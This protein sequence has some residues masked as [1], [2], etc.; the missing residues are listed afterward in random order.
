MIMAEDL[1]KMWMK[2]SLT[3]EESVDL[4][5]PE[6]ELH[7]G[8]TRGKFYVLGK[9]IADRMVSKETIK[10]TL[11]RWWKLSG[12][13]SFQVLGENLFL[14]EFT[15]MEDKKWILEGRPWIFEGSLF[16]IEDFDGISSP[17]SFNFDRAGFWVRMIDLPLACIN[18]TT[19]KRIGSTVGLVE[20]VDTGKDG[21]GW[22]EFLRVKIVEDLSKPLAHGRMLKI[23]GKSNWIA[24]QY[25]HLPKFCFHCAIINHGKLDVHFGVR[26]TTRRI[27]LNMVPGCGRLHQR[28]GRKGEEEDN[29][30][31]QG[32]P[33]M[34]SQ[35]MRVYGTMFSAPR[36]WERRM[37]ATLLGFLQT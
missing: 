18:Q 6:E 36:S 31:G 12:T 3:E 20:A 15:D 29:Q 24:F 28:E 23:Q 7:D 22:G 11:S 34:R 9:L 8:V 13:L 21:I 4:D 10:T 17:S 30:H 27:R 37:A 14:I 2:L 16:I 26:C 32:H 35:S 19:G 25:E 5:T 33:S 1:S